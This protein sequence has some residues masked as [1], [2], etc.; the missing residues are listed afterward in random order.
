MDID[1][2][3]QLRE[4]MAA[5]LMEAPDPQAVSSPSPVILLSFSFLFLSQ[6]QGFSPPV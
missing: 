3:Q 2:S 5:G 4:S 6:M 1:F